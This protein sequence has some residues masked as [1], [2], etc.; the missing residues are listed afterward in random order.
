MTPSTRR[1]WLTRSLTLAGAPMLGLAQWREAFS[2]VSTGAGPYG[3]L[4]E[5]DANGVRLPK[6][7]TARLIAVSGERVANSRYDWHF[8]PDGGATFAMR[9]GGWV[10][11]CNAELNG[12]AGGVGAIRFDASGEIV[13]AYPILSGTKYNC[14]GGA[15]PWGTWLS[16]EE[17]RNGRVWEC[18]PRRAGQGVVRPALGVFSHEAAAVDPS[19]GHV[20]LTEDDSTGRLYRFVPQTAGQLD[21]GRLEAAFVGDGGI[22]S[23]VPVPPT[24]PYRGADSTA[25]ARGEGAWFSNGVLYFCTTS[26]NRF[27]ALE[28]GTNRLTVLYD[29]AALG[30]AAPLREP[31]NVTVHERTGDIYVC[32]DDDNLE[33]VLL[34]AGRDGRVAASFLQFVGHEGSEV[35]GAA[36]SPDGNRLYLSSQRGIGRKYDSP[37]MT[38][39]ILGPFRR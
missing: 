34:A 1:A 4:V 37:G 36:F 33:C 8:Q 7:F 5:P 38:F 17:F 6:G 22:V 21:H 23:W 15:T 14:A 25:F 28:P 39:E 18:D 13:G 16:C 10:Y 24:R 31:D 32:E 2:Q 35:A 29:A 30:A 12:T 11:A 27:W 19:T 20:Y 3:P 26:D 9:D